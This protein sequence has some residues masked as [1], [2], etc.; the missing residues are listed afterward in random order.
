MLLLIV[1]F[2]CGCAAAPEH[3]TRYN[4][5]LADAD[6]GIR[7]VY[8]YECSDQNTVVQNA[9]KMAEAIAAYCNSL[10]PERI[11][12]ENELRARTGSNWATARCDD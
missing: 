6:L 2:L 9:E 12:F 5:C 1:S 11:A 8:D 10:G 4:A 7:H 3:S